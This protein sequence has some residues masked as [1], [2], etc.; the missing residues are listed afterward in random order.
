M[1]S[2]KIESYGNNRMR[3]DLD[4]MYE[5]GNVNYLPVVLVT[6]LILQMM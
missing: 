3:N 6:H 2:S 4:G 5:C 1:S